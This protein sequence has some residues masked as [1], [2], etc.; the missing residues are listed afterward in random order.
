MG[1]EVE[2]R[3]RPELLVQELKI[4]RVDKDPLRSRG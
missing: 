3:T 4:V 1:Y 2:A